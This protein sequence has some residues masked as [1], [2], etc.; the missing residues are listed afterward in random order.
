MSHCQEDI[1]LILR[2]LMMQNEGKNKLP[3]LLM[4]LKDVDPPQHTTRTTSFFPLSLL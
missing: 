4:H 1:W 2:K 3:M